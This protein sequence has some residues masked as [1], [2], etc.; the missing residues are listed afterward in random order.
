M[1]AFRR[2]PRKEWEAEL[3]QYGCYPAEGMTP[4]N[5]TGAEWWRYPWGGYPF[6]V[7]VDE[8]GWLGQ[9]DLDDLIMDLIQLANEYRWEF[10][11][12]DG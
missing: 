8:D 3:R 7:A 9:V 12:D 11:N 1:I 4:L 10:P 2:R 6:P 5:E